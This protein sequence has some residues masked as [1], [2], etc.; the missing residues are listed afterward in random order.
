MKQMKRVVVR[1]SLGSGISSICLVGEI[2]KTI[3]SLAR[4][5]LIVNNVVEDGATGNR[6]AMKAL[7][8]SSIEDVIERHLTDNLRRLY[9]QW[10]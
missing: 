1:Y 5:G 2:L 9:C 6:S 8:T 7:E 4:H 10:I 3:V